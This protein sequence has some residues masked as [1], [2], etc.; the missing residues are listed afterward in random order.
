MLL[1]SD[2]AF[3]NVDGM[4]FKELWLELDS[5]AKAN[6]AARAQTSVP[7]LSQVAH[8]HRKAG[9]ALIERLLRADNRITFLMMRP[10]PTE[11]A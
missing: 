6:L 3:A 4:T 9:A 2:L 7:Y 1:I 5:Q 11:A 10:E 8:G